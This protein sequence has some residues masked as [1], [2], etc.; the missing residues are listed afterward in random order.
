MNDCQA[1][2][3]SENL[4]GTNLRISSISPT[5]TASEVVQAVELNESETMTKRSQEGKQRGPVLRKREVTKPTQYYG[6]E[7]EPG[8]SVSLRGG[9]V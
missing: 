8:K 5:R 7:E 6:I 2:P 3:N 4:G 9:L 1:L